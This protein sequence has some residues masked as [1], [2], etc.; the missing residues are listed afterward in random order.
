ML[1]KSDSLKEK[2]WYDWEFGMFSKQFFY[3]PEWNLCDLE[4]KKKIPLTKLRIGYSEV[5][6]GLYKIQAHEGDLSIDYPIYSA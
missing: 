1:I 6:S 5:I 4:K 2:H 3:I